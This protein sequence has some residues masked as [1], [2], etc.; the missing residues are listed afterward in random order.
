MIEGSFCRRSSNPARRLRELLDNPG[1]VRAP[2]VGDA[3]SAKLVALGTFEAVHLSGSAVS[4]TLALPDL[5][6]VTLTEMIDRTRSIVR[7]VD[8]PVIA[9]A[10]SGYGNAINLIRTVEEFEAAG[11]AGIHIEDQV[12]PKRCGHY[13]SKMLISPREMALKIEAACTSR[14][15]SDFVIIARTDARAVEGFQS[16]LERAKLYASAGADVLFI[17]A[18]ESLAE[19]EEIAATLHEP[20]MLNMFSGGKTP[21]ISVSHLRQLGYKIVIFPSHLQRAAIHAMQRALDLLK[22]E[23]ESA[24]NDPDLMISFEER[25]AILGVSEFY[26]LERRYLVES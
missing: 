3:L 20:L 14:E 16:A 19:V 10:D 6:L 2:G 9:D 12:T 26:A 5:G 1:L 24:A 23:D 21:A 17:E 7:A 25:E 11:A 8:L 4:R 15:N 13:G 22:R 18:P